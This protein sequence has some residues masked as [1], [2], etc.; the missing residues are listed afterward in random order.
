[1]RNLMRLM[2]VLLPISAIV[3]FV[4]PCFKAEAIRPGGGTL[5]GKVYGYNMY[6]EAIPLVWARVSAYMN[7]QLVGDASTGFNGTYVMFL[8]S[9][10]LSV[11]VEYPGFKTQVRA[12]AISDG[13]SAQ[14]NFYLERSEIPIPE[15]RASYLPITAMSLLVVALVLTKR[16]RR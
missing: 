10:Q 5:S 12:V 4:S 1:M 15:F 8:P 2:L 9:G 13:G 11:T 14:M 16:R 7:N 3:L 6:D